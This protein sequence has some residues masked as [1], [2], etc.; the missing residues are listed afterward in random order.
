MI[1]IDCMRLNLFHTWSNGVSCPNFL[2]ASL[3]FGFTQYIM[4]RCVPSGCRVDLTTAFQSVLGGDDLLSH[5]VFP[6]RF[7]PNTWCRPGSLAGSS[8]RFPL[9]WA[10]LLDFPCNLL[11]FWCLVGLVRLVFVILLFCSWAW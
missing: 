4:S 8:L 5:L 1:L 2:L 7:R 9:G 11:C 10:F 3:L 6:L